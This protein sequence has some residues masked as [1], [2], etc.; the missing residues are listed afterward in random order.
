MWCRDG[1][2]RLKV[3]VMRKRR[4][5]LDIILL[6]RYD[7]ILLMYCFCVVS[8]FVSDYPFVCI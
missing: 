8:D 5:L 7:M 4:R 3:R 6:E 2:K 1:K